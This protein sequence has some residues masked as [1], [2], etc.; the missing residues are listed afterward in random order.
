M[1][2]S[3][4]KKYEK[5]IFEMKAEGKTNAKISKIL[6]KKDKGLGADQNSLKVF[7]KRHKDKKN[8]KKQKSIA[9]TVPEN[10][11]GVQKKEEKTPT[12]TTKTVPENQEGIQKKEKPSKE[13]IKKDMPKESKAPVLD[14]A[15]LKAVHKD[16]VNT[17]QDCRGNCDAHSIMNN[18]LGV[19]VKKLDNV[20]MRKANPF[21]ITGI[22]FTIMAAFSLGDI[23]ITGCLPRRDAWII[24]APAGL[25]FMVALNII[26]LYKAGLG[27]FIN[28]LIIGGTAFISTAALTIVLKIYIPG[29]TGLFIGLAIVALTLFG[30]IF[31]KKKDN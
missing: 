13:E 24:G 2:G 11:E 21:L 5:E 7:L 9:K 15:P 28:K 27:R 30:L 23:Y 25:P 16:F 1:K 6:N 18:E 29:E 12:N 14:T 17:Q 20:A 19:A 31:P 26:I 4:Y 22:F 8:G 3:K 10:Q